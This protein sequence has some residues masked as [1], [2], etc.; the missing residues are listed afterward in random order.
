NSGSVIT[1]GVSVSLNAGSGA[2]N[3]GQPLT[4]SVIAP[5]LTAQATTNSVTNIAI[6]LG[7]DVTSLS[8]TALGAAQAISITESNAVTL[9]SLTTAGGNITITAGGTITAENVNSGAADTSL[10]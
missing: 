7:T 2:I 8:A 9:T 6:S 4:P 1:A 3:D 10:T 5:T